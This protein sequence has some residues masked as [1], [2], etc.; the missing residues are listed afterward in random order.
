[1]TVLFKLIARITYIATNQEAGIMHNRH[2]RCIGILLEVWTLGADATLLRNGL[3]PLCPQPP[4][5]PPKVHVDHFW[6]V[7]LMKTL[8]AFLFSFLN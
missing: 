2:E 3:G 6:A 7:F 1:M 5:P 4:P 8:Y